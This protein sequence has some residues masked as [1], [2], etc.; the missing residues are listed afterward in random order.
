MAFI[1]TIAP[2]EAT[3]EVREMYERQ[4][5]SWGLCRTTPRCSA[6]ARRS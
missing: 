3:G 4:Q 5:Q 2:E 6:T 1:E